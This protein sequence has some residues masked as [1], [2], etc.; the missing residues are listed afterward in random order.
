VTPGESPRF[1]PWRVLLTVHSR[2]HSFVMGSPE[3]ERGRWEAEG[4]Q[5]RVTLTKGF[6]LG[7]YE[8]T[9]R[10]YLAV[11]GSKPSRFQP[12]D[13]AEDLDRPVECVSWDDAVAYCQKLT[14]QERAAG[15]LPSGY[16]YRLPNEAQWEYACRAGTTTRSSLGDALGCDDECDFC[17]LL[18]S[19]VWWCGNDNGE[20]THR[21]GHKLPNPWG[22]YDMHGNVLEWCGDWWSD[23]LAGGSV[24]A[25]AGPDTGSNRV[26]R[27]GYWYGFA[28]L[29]RSAYR[30]D[31]DPG[32]W[33]HVIGFRV[34]LAPGQP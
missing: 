22:L 28:R 3:T 1:Y 16:E 29:C 6:W 2:V 17:A 24:I 5:T 32:D 15:R 4:P 33:S 25:P 18:D 31:S 26:I 10:E 19:Y 7:K 34:L 21:V 11:M 8:V 14:E 23:H 30:S 9:Q 13:F 20:G 12:P 27:G